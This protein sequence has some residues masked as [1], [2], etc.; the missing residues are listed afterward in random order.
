MI[1][2][3]IIIFFCHRDSAYEFPDEICW[4]AVSQTESDA[5]Y[6]VPGVFN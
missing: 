6:S 4:N 1:I 2:S 5:L 3:I